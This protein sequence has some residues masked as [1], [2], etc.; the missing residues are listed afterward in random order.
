MCLLDSTLSKGK[1]DIK[2]LFENDLYVV[3]KK[4][5]KDQNS[6]IVHIVQHWDY[7]ASTK[8]MLLIGT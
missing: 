7:V 1:M 3:C 6:K 2:Y 5:R 8:V 4:K